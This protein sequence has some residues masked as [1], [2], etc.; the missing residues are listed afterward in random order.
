M[1]H[2]LSVANG[3]DGA[4][5][6]VALALPVDFDAAGARLGLEALRRLVLAHVAIEV[7]ALGDIPAQSDEKCKSQCLHH[8]DSC[9]SQ[10]VMNLPISSA[11]CFLCS[12]SKLW[13]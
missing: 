4:Q 7:L 13:A 9:F 3:K 10:Y 6:L 11:S 12:F 8:P 5:L 1:D 2:R